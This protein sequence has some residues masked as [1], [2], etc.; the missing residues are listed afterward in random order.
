MKRAEM[1]QRIAAEHVSDPSHNS[2]C[3][4]HPVLATSASAHRSLT[5]RYLFPSAAAHCFKVMC[6]I[7]SDVLRSASMILHFRIVLLA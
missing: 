2:A 5:F 3:D 1:V 4:A 6:F 7:K